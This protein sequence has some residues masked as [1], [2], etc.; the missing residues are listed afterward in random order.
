MRLRGIKITPVG[1]P[2]SQWLLCF[3]R[4]FVLI[5]L[6][7]ET[8]R[9]EAQQLLLGALDLYVGTH[10]PRQRHRDF[11]LTLTLTVC[12]VSPSTPVV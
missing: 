4:V 11:R 5:P 8:V 10:D 6:G 2:S 12:R 9:F 3:G 1:S 7:E